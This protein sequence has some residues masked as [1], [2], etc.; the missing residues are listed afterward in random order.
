MFKKRPIFGPKSMSFSVNNPAN[1]FFFKILLQ[2]LYVVLKFV[3]L[4]TEWG[5]RL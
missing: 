1:N 3:P 2:P 5:W 4:P